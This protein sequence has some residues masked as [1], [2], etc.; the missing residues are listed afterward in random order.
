VSANNAKCIGTDQHF[1]V[2][3][4]DMDD[5]QK[6]SSNGSTPSVSAG[7]QRTLV[8]RCLSSTSAAFNVQEARSLLAKFPGGKV[9]VVKNER[10]GIATVCLNRPDKKNAI[11]GES[12]K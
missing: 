6:I 4:D 9:D 8:H 11:S 5:C 1:G 3:R 7:M 12:P 10:T 2:G